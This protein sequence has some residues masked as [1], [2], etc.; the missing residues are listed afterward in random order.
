MK[1][2]LFA[3]LAAV[4]IALVPLQLPAAAS[5]PAAQ[6]SALEIDALNKFLAANPEVGTFLGDYSH[7]GDWSDPSAAGLAAAKQMIDAYE[8]RLNAIDMTGAT[9]QDRNDVTLMR[10]FMVQQRRNLADAEA[11]KDPSGPPLAVLGTIFTMILHKDEQDPSVWWEHV[12][13]RLEKAPAFMAAAKP[14]ITNPGRL[15]AQVA[16]KQL[17]MAPALF[18]FILTPMAASLPADQKARFEKARDGTLGAIN[19]WTSWMSTNAASWPIN[20]AMGADAYNAML[21]DELLLPYDAGQIAAIGQKT[22]DAAVAKERQIQAEAK[23]RG[24]NLSNPAQ[25]AASGGGMTPTTKDAQFAFFQTQLDTLRSFVTAKRIVTIPAYVGRMTI[26]ETPP[27]LQP[28]LPGPSMQSPPIL[29]KQVDGVYFVPPPNPQMAKAA[30]SGAIF[31]DFDRDRVLMTSGHEGIPG[32]FLQLSIA[33]HNEDPVRRFTFD[34][35]FAEGWAFYE[36]ALLDREGL[37]GND[38]DG[39]YAVAQFE[40]LR[41]AR[42]IVDTK[43]ATAAWSYD[44]AVAWYVAHA[45]VDRATAEGEV[46]R[47]ALGPGQAFD[48]AV[49]K[50][51]IEALLAQYKAKKG[52]A[53]DLQAFHD[54]LLSHGTVPL[55]IVASEMLAE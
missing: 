14:L 25:A 1:K 17:A 26:V 53:F 12:I 50:T 22:L 43:L 3:G 7:D 36:E 29:S 28:V 9:L 34:G 38:L 8:Q 30:A 23:A 4:F 46:S 49:G 20:Y 55:S 6:I 27:F 40:R 42:A 11:G 48:Y 54:D 5:A 45:G 19:A 13:S 39:R 51:Q 18:T 21:K 35:V 2:R 52:G 16:L 31:E 44:Q 37:Y 24:I 10:A 32:H 47:F 15:Q 33:K 41:G